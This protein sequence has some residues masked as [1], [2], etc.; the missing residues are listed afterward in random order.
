MNLN[1]Y[2][3]KIPFKEPFTTSAGTLEYREGLILEFKRDGILAYGEA[4]P[5]PGSSHETIDEVI[6]QFRQ[7]FDTISSALEKNALSEHTF[8]SFIDTLYP[9]LGFALDTMLF[10]SLSQLRT[11]RPEHILF[12]HPASKISVNA[13]LPIDEFEKT[14]ELA[15]YFDK[16]G[17]DTFKLKVGKNFERERSIIEKISK[18]HPHRKIRLDANQSWSSDEAEEYLNSLSR[19]NIEYCE[20]PVREPNPEKL[21][22]LK[23]KIEIPIALDE[24]LLHFKEPEVLINRDIASILIIKPML[25]GSFQKKIETFPFNKPH[26]YTA[27][28]TTSLESG[29][30]RMMTATLASGLGAPHF[31]HGLATGSLLK[32]DVWYDRD[33]INSGYFNLPD[34]FGVDKKYQPKIKDLILQ[35][36]T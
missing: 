36:I 16:Q 35:S 19:H 4:A 18:H 29:I 14:L 2:R 26:E 1:A 22:S 15:S 12:K 13:V 28:F 27:V 11:R 20:E 5:L 10:S 34:G 31:A 9:S 7:M 30:G 25:W 33:Y 21:R 23:K 3:Y 6:L 32:M 24:S 17:F 8:S